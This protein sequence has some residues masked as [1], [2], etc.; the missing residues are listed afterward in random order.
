MAPFAVSSQYCIDIYDGGSQLISVPCRPEVN[1]SNVPRETI[2]AIS[3]AAG[4]AAIAMVR[5]SG[6]NAI[7]VADKI[8]RGKQRPSDLESQT[9]H[10]GEIVANGAIIDQAM[11][12]VHHAPASY[13]GE[14]LVE[15]S[16]HGGALVT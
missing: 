5:I 14:D 10:L 7:E 2:A 6:E 9:Q 4:E 13:T 15:I 3:T 11:L 16:C 1:R 8:F 12:S